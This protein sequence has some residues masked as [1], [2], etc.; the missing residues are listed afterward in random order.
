MTAP[1]ERRDVDGVVVLRLKRPPVNALDLAALAALTEAF[2]QLAATPP[3]CGLVLASD[4]GHFSAGLDLKVFRATDEAGR[5]AMALAINPMIVALYGLPFPTAAA[6]EGA[7]LAGGLVLALG[8][9]VRVAADARVSLG[10]AEVTAGVPFPVGA[11]EVCR[12]ELSAEAQRQFFL[13]DKR[14]DGVEGLRM[15][16]VDAVCSAVDLEREAVARVQTLAQKPAYRTIKR[17]LRA[18][19]LASIQTGLQNGDPVWG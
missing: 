12:A 15:G 19:T 6:I 11:L 13:H 16:V 14:V 10:L 17:Q 5:R 1:I 3:R 4:G 8:C 7:A 18:P 2:T 9:D